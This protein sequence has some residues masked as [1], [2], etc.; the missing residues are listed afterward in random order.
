MKFPSL[1]TLRFFDAAAK[2]G[3]FVKAAEQLNV[4]HSAI[5]RQIRILEEQLG[6][7]LF[8]RRNRAVFLTSEG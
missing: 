3:S 2:S 6:V 5:S 4:T 1:S 8:E 7:A